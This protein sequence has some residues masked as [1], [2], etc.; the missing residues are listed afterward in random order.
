LK[1]PYLFLF[2]LNDGPE[3]RFLN[4]EMLVGFNIGG[5]IFEPTVEVL[6]RDPYSLL[7]SCCRE[8][9][10]IPR[11]ADGLFY[12]DRDWWLFRHIIS[13]LRSNILPTDLE[14]LK[15]LYTEAS[16]YRLESLQR[17]IEEIPLSSIRNTQR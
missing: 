16:F 5:Q 4:P 8:N 15:E 12:F 9:P 17:S 1:I 2:R 13:F 10:P 14:T 3:F 11:D 6:M 7:A